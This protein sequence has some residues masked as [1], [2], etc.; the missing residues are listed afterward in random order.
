MNCCSTAPTGG[1]E[2]PEKRKSRR[3]FRDSNPETFEVHV[4]ELCS[5]CYCGDLL[6]VERLVTRGA[7][8]H[9]VRPAWTAPT[10]GYWCAKLS[11]RLLSAAVTDGNRAGCCR[12][13]VSV[14]PV[15]IAAFQGRLSV[16]K[17]LV[18]EGRVNAQQVGHK[19]HAVHLAGG[20]PCHLSACPSARLS[21]GRQVGSFE[22]ST[23]L[24]AASDHWQCP[25]CRAALPAP[26]LRINPPSW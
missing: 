1:G 22:R 16:V 3:Q 6:A 11:S 23:P 2:K 10:G 15:W 4:D 7:D 9:R 14:P 24:E 25:G 17:Y 18:Q 12:T 13:R 21:R 19:H 20:D 5:A 26:D 8:P